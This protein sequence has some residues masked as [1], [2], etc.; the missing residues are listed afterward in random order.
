MNGVKWETRVIALKQ[1]LRWSLWE[2]WNHWNTWCKWKPWNQSSRRNQRYGD[3]TDIEKPDEL[4]EIIRIPWEIKENTE[5]ND[6]T[7]FDGIGEVKGYLED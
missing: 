4:T 2:L 1:I 3:L 7:G 5:I 6:F